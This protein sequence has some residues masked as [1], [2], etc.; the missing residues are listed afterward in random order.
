MP[1]SGQSAAIVEALACGQSGCDCQRAARRGQGRTH[2]PVHNDLTASL[3]V[4]PKGDNVVWHC[5]AGCDQRLVLKALVDLNLLA[6]REDR[7]GHGHNQVPSIVATYPYRDEQGQVLHETVRF[8]PKSFRQRRPDGHGGWIWSL[9]GIT[10][11]VLYRLPE[12]LAADP[13]SPVFVVEGEK[14]VDRLTAAGLVATTSPMG[15]GKWRPEYSDALRDRNV[16]VLPDNDPAGRQH[17]V[18]VANSLHATAREVRI[19]TLPELPEKGDVSDW[20][21]AGHSA[22]ELLD[23]VELLKAPEPERPPRRF[24]FLTAEELKARPDPEWLVEGVLQRD[25]LA[26][27]VGAQESFKSFLALSLGMAIATGR[28][29]HGHVTCPGVVAFISA[30]GG[31]GIGLRIEAWETVHGAKADQAYFLVDQAPQLLDRHVAG[32]VD[33]LLLS[34]KDLPSRPALIVIDTLARSM[35]GGDENSAEDMGLL[36]AAAERIRQATAA[37]VVLVHHYN[38]QGGARGSTA[39]LG[40]VHTIVECSRETNSPHLLVRCGK[41]KDSDHFPPMLFDARVVELGLNPDTGR[42]RSSLV[43]EPRVSQVLQATQGP[44]PLMPTSQQALTAFVR[45]RSRGSHLRPVE[46]RGEYS[47]EID[48]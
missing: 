13:A 33:E 39:L 25:T 37:T 7:N 23:L 19:V 41:Q 31:S 16:V 34:L 17:A 18:T 43:L 38:K 46:G 48:L 14:D 44:Q 5:H 32:D 3:N 27:I 8:F 15:A 2:C 4:E 6:P 21:D 45:P 40:A 30:E 42:L 36:I 24:R 28:G 26:L 20:L 10:R 29:W 35:V 9:Q 1:S 47:G 22:A 12:L 11:V